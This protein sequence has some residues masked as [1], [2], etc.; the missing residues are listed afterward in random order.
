[1]GV[2]TVGVYIMC[3]GSDETN[4]GFPVGT[5]GISQFDDWG[6]AK[7][8][9]D[10]GR[11]ADYIYPLQPVTALVYLCSPVE[12]V[13]DFEISGI[14]H[15]GSDVTTAINAAI[16]NVFFEGGN[17]DGTGKIYISDL[18]RAIGDIEG[19]AGFIL[20]LPSVNIILGVGQLPVRGEVIY[21]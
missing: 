16:D 8:T 1:M 15:V 10:Q 3:D 4:H 18:N 21:T 17:P 12:K 6:A 9:G 14:S 19:T 11:V 20:V 7:A 5:D 2:G 13:I